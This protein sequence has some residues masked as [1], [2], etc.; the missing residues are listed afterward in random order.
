MDAEDF[1]I[2]GDA[3]REQ[4]A[5]DDDS[6]SSPGGLQSLLDSAMATQIRKSLTEHKGNRARAAIALGIDRSTLNRQMK[7]LSISSLVRL[8]GQDRQFCNS[9]S[10]EAVR[11]GIL[12]W[13]RS[14]L[15]ALR[16]AFD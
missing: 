6:A 15:R 16:H 5:P 14:T 8:P 13:A 3:L 1:P 2:A 12:C 9:R 7:R 11:N 10:R 4:Q